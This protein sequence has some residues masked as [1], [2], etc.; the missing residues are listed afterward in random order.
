M[1]SKK[2]KI[3]LNVSSP[4]GYSDLSHLSCNSVSADLTPQSV[5]NQ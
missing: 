4:E 2:L 5:K 3:E 1:I